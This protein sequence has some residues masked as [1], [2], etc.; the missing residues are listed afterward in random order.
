MERCA[1]ES[2]RTISRK[3]SW[4]LGVEPEAEEELTRAA[5]WYESKREGL[6]YEFV[7]AIDQVLASITRQPLG[8][9]IWKHSPDHRKAVVR[10]FPYVIFFRIVDRGP[11][12]CQTF[13]VA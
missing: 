6:G 12:S 7:A 3:V 5:E 13:G 11:T 1:V 2:A 10:K 4:I 8:H 9:P